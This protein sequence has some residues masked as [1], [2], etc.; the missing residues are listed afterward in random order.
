[1][2]NHLDA[3]LCQRIVEES[4]D[5][6]IFADQEGIIRLWNSGAEAMFKVT[7]IEA[8]RGNCC[9]GSHYNC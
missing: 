8:T 9:T 3:E 5:G 7:G 6:I 4:Q 1:M 2:P